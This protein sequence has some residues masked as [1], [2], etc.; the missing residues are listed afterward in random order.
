MIQ[1]TTV[2]WYIVICKWA[3]KTRRVNVSRP[4]RNWL[5]LCH[6]TM[7]LFFF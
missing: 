6:L 2:T 7:M 3:V 4:I 1:V 5:W